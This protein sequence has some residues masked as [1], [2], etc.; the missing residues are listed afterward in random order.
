M[1]LYV[2]VEENAFLKE[3]QDKGLARGREEG[4]EEGM[5]ALLGT[6]LEARFGKLP[7]W[8]LRRIEEGSTSQLARWGR[9]LLKAGSLEEVLGPR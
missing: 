8:A 9:K 5:S 1:P 7:R 3:I 6:Q 4:R 2:E